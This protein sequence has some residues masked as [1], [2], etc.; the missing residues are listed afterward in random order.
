MRARAK[1]TYVAIL[2]LCV[3]GVQ[4]RAAFGQWAAGFRPFAHAPA[5]VPYSWDMFAIRL[6]RCVV[7][8]DPPLSIDGV[9]V[10]RW[11][12]RVWPI[13]FDSVYN[14]VDSYDAVAA[15][16]CAY[17]TAPATA[18]ALECFL[19]DGGADDHSIA[20]P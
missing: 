7:R 20:C 18:I 14:D 17:R 19:G 5:R 4:V 13:E 1:V 11:S 2:L 8:W 15:A 6:D 16:A 3:A 12:D 10:A 9:R